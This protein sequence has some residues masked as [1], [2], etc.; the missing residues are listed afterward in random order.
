MKDD[1]NILFSYFG[2]L[3][4]SV[5]DALVEADDELRLF[6]EAR[7]QVYDPGKRIRGESWD[8]TAEGRARRH[9][10]HF[11]L[12]LQ[13]ALDG[14]AD[15]SAL[16]FTRLVPDLRLGRAQFSRL[17]S[18]L[19]RPLPVPGL[20]VSPQEHLLRQLYDA[21]RPL[22]YPDGPDRD[23]LRLMR[24]FR[25][26]AAHLGD[27]VFRYVVLHDESDRFYTF[28]PRQW[29]YIW[30]RHMKPASDS[31][32]QDPD[33]LPTLFRETLTHQ[34]INSWVRGLRSTVHTVLDSGLSVLNVAF[35]TV[36]G[37]PLNQAA[38]AQLNGSSEF[39][40]FEYF[41]SSVDDRDG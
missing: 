29:P 7:M 36:E 4:R 10:R 14:F 34:D 19:A 37:F 22:V 35:R 2:M 12:S 25:N 38:L 21:L 32:P 11:I 39:H 23:W 8:P 26:K 28:L 30:E 41:P 16:F 17:E 18:W 15:T 20:V 9:F 27:A 40:T 31:G 24:L 1:E 33:R 13:T 6:V 5:M 3:L